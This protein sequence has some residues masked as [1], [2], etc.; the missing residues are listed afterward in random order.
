[1]TPEALVAFLLLAQGVMGGVDTLLNHELIERL[2]Y[3]L[4]ARR[5]IGLHAIR[6]A[7]YGALFCG[8]AWQAWHGALALA[9]AALL[10]AEVIVTASDELVENHTRVLPNNERVLHVFLTLNLGVIIALMVPTLWVWA[11]QPTAL[12]AS[13]KGW[14]SWALTALG[15]ASAAWSLRDL[16]AWRRLRRARV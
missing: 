15:L 16:F 13:D 9:I 1:V 12:V 5:E 10:A 11:S 4:Q 8:L 6:E 7:I 14:V 3:R 2:P